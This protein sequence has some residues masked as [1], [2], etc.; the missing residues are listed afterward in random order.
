MKSGHLLGQQVRDTRVCLLCLRR[1]LRLDP[2]ISFFSTAVGL[3]SVVSAGPGS[4]QVFH[5]AQPVR[6]CLGIR[7]AQWYWLYRAINRLSNGI[8]D[9][10]VGGWDEHANSMLRR[11]VDELA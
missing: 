1:L 7:P 9:L 10:S 4:L 3:I 6:S 2:M 5:L 11:V 8:L